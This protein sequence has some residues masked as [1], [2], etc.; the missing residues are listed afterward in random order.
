[1]DNCPGG[2]PLR[3]KATLCVCVHGQ[4]EKGAGVR[5]GVLSVFSVETGRR[6]VNIK[7]SSG[8]DLSS[9]PEL[10]PCGRSDIREG[11]QLRGLQTRN[12]MFQF[13]LL[14]MRDWLSVAAFA[15]IFAGCL[16]FGLHGLLFEY[17][18]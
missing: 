13:E 3:A 8:Q 4:W 10:G 7:V 5:A 17:V 14:T 18:N 9:R 1:M 16:Y 15:V 11:R 2:L 6:P 12:W